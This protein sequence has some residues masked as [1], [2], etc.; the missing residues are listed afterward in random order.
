[1]KLFESHTGIIDKFPKALN[2]DDMLDFLEMKL[3]QKGFGVVVNVVSSQCDT[4]THDTPIFSGE[5]ECVNGWVKV[6]CIHRKCKKKKAHWAVY[7][8]NYYHT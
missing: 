6:K 7:I 5:F 8:T 1:M 4:G 2:A 3:L